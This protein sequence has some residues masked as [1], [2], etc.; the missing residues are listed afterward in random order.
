VLV[1]GSLPFSGSPLSGLLFSGSS[2]GG[3]HYVSCQTCTSIV[4]QLSQGYRYQPYWKEHHLPREFF[5]FDSMERE[6]VV[7]VSFDGMVP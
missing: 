3:S 2:P 1:T 4:L 5:G 6:E 7:G